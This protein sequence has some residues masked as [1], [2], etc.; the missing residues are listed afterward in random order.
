MVTMEDKNKKENKSRLAEIARQK[1]LK[2]IQ[3]QNTKIKANQEYEKK[4]KK[5]NDSYKSELKE[6]KNLPKI[7]ISSQ[8][9]E[10][11]IKHKE[12]IIN[13]KNNSNDA[14]NK[15]NSANKDNNYLHDVFI[16]KKTELL[17]IKQEN[18]TFKKNLKS[19]KKTNISNYKNK[20]I[21]I[22]NKR[23]NDIFN[24]Q[25]E[26]DLLIAKNYYNDKL[27]EIQKMKISKKI[28]YKQYKK[29]LI[30]V[31]N[32]F[33]NQNDSYIQSNYVKKKQWR[34]SYYA[35]LLKYRK[36]KKNK[37]FIENKESYWRQYETIKTDF[38]AKLTNNKIFYQNSLTQ[39]RQQRDA[40]YPFELDSAFAL[41][42]W[43]Y[44]I[45]KEFQRMTWPTPRR[46]MIDFGIVAGVSLFIALL[47]SLI[48][49]LLTLF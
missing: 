11:K 43:W 18:K 7:D 48:D 34:I 24:A 1:Q 4:L 38:E 46:S 6:L 12:N 27:A 22:I 17:N 23:E 37:E 26:R 45:G 32:L 35:L 30:D 28:A 21:E 39:L 25:N 41:K 16:I 31:E 44:G 9:N 47:Y 49:Y 10:L 36:D 15:L 13:I 14:L 20:K 29:K 40:A 2:K 3:Y 33:K 42:R 8:I 19:L 5:I